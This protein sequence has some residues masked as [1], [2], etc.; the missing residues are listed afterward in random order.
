MA[1]AAVALV[2]L[3]VGLLASRRRSQA[4]AKWQQLSVGALDAAELSLGL[5]PAAGPLVPDPSHWRSVRDS[6]ER[7]AAG[8]D[9]VAA[10]APTD[11]G[12]LGGSRA[13]ESL[14]S[15]LFA[16]ESDQLLRSAPVAPTG[17]QLAQSDAVC[18][19]RRADAGGALSNLETLV[20]PPRPA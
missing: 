14:R 1:V 10:S 13:A 7:A 2:A 16:L 19:Q 18:R 9:R 17:E 3:V 5:L 15:L 8:L 4:L 20:R 6:V 12:R 11:D